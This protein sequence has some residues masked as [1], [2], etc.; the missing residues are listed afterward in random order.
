M[1]VAVFGLAVALCCATV[2]AA[3][4]EVEPNNTLATATPLDIS[5]IGV[6]MGIARLS[7][8]GGDVDFFSIAL[9]VDDILTAITTP[10]E[11]PLWV[12]DTMMGVFDAAGTI[13]VFNDDSGLDTWG[14]AVNFLS[15]ETATFYIGVTGWDDYG[16]VGDHEEVGNY[17]LKV[18]VVPEPATILTLALCSP[19]LLARR[20]R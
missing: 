1:K 14:S 3:I 12:P 4:E 20:R 13:L 7:D 5:A 18:S 9:N 11:A 8:A 15:P 6:D 17:A 19:L 10:L 16:F 2:Q